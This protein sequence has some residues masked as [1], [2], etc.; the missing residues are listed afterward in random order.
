MTRTRLGIVAV[1]GSLVL[2]A[3]WAAGYQRPTIPVDLN[4]IK[5]TFERLNSPVT[6][7]FFDTPVA[8]AIEFL[9]DFSKVK[10][11]PE[12]EALPHKTIKIHLEQ[13]PFAVAIQKVLDQCDWTFALRPDGNIL[14]RPVPQAK[15]K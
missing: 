10:F 3:T 4:K 14:L 13:E 12:A 11:D 9:Q 5:A 15:K 1:L 8:D 2:S 6:L 7:E